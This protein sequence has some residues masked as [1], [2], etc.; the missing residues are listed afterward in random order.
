M[1]CE[2]EKMSTFAVDGFIHPL[3]KDFERVRSA[4]D[5]LFFAV[6]VHILSKNPSDLWSACPVDGLGIGILRICKGEKDDSSLFHNREE[7]QF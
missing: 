3:Y 5:P 2:S 7:S 4:S 6:F 1:I